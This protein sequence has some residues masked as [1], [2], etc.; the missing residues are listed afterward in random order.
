MGIRKIHFSHNVCSHNLQISSELHE[1]HSE[2]KNNRECQ[3]GL[4]PI[5]P[6]KINP[7]NVAMIDVRNAIR[8]KF[9][10]LGTKRFF[11][12]IL[13]YVQIFAKIGS[14]GRP[15]PPVPSPENFAKNSS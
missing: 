11:T 13:I 5:F 10:I 2:I 15:K 8:M 4:F 14:Q 3:K 1:I 12:S 9:G 6:I 7:I